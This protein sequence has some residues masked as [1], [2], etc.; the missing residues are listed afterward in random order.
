[1]YEQVLERERAPRAPS[2]LLEQHGGSGGAVRA[3]LCPLE[4]YLLTAAG[5][6]TSAACC[7]GLSLN[8][9]N[10]DAVQSLSYVPG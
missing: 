7:H 8:F 6:G 9:M 3:L 5:N 4:Y 2:R 1:M 10:P